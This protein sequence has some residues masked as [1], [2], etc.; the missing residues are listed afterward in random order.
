MDSVGRAVASF[1]PKTQPYMLRANYA[2]ELAAWSVLPL[3]LGVVEGGVV[4]VLA[5]TYFAGTVSPSTLNMTVAILAGA[6]AF[7]NIVSFL[8]AAVSHG[9]HKIRMLTAL[10]VGA[11]TCVLLVAVAPRSPIGLLLVTMGAVGARVCWSGVVTVRSTVWRANY[12]RRARARLAGKLA[13]VQALAMSAAG[14]GVG[15][16][17]KLDDN[18]FRLLYPVAA[19]CGFVGAWIYS[20]LRLRGHRALL[21]AERSNVRGARIS[22][23]QLRRVLLTDPRFRQYMTCMFVFG[24][25]NL[26]V[27]APLVIM[28]KDRFDLDPFVSVLIAATVSTLLMPVSIPIWS[29]L[30]DRVHVIEFRAIHSWTFVASTGTFLLGL[31]SNQVWLLWLG[32]VVKGIAYGGG[33][34]GWNLGHHDFAPVERASQYMGVH[35][36][37]TGLRGILAPMIAVSLY[38]ILEWVHPGSGPWTL[39]VCLALTLTGAVWFVF[40]RRTLTGPGGDSEFEDG[41]PIQP[42]AAG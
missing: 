22:P 11:A 41:P 3:M 7:A 36:T 33:V 9:R 27:T 32:A 21:R 25:G 31:V 1:H 24:T 38:E 8:W 6:P 34:L 15:A 16:A 20:G 5:K 18:A 30:L 26:M 35:V 23:L 37:L 13:T 40:M 2:R 28:L 10:Q 39:A 17:M 29:R 4:A 14:L 42:P 12:P 19:V